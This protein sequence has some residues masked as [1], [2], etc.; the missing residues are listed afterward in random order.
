MRLILKVITVIALLSTVGCQLPPSKLETSGT[1][2]ERKERMMGCVGKFLNQ[3]VAPSD[4][5]AICTT[6]FSRYEP[7][8][9]PKQL[10]VKGAE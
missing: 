8:I 10:P 7:S 9:E 6:V 1:R 4:S 3:D 5:L 2:F